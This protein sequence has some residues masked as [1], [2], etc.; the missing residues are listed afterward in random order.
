[1]HLNCIFTCG[2]ADR[3]SRDKFSSSVK[4]QKKAK[5]VPIDGSSSSNNEPISPKFLKNY[6]KI[7]KN[8]LKKISKTHLNSNHLFPSMSA[9]DLL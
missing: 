4:V 7:L 1:M 5:T 3:S 2:E 8:V 9:A 6:P